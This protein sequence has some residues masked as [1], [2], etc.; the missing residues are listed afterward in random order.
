[1]LTANINLLNTIFTLLCSC[2]PNLNI[3]DSIIIHFKHMQGRGHIQL[4]NSKTTFKQLYDYLLIMWIY[5]YLDNKLFRIANVILSDPPFAECRVPS[6]IHN[7]LI[8]TLDWSSITDFFIFI[9]LLFFIERS[10]NITLTVPLSE[11]ALWTLHN[12]FRIFKLQLNICLLIL[13]IMVKCDIV[14]LC[15][16]FMYILYTLC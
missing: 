6:P 4:W 3:C 14:I 15:I 7:T 5:L 1:M 9:S 13:I 10:I 16:I 11:M 8:E 12:S 2:R